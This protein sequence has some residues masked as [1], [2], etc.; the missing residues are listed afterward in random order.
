MFNDEG[1]VR[2]SALNSV[3]K[4][5]PIHEEENYEITDDEVVMIPTVFSKGAVASP[6]H[7][8]TINM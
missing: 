1:Q 3:K 7:L 4:T 8:K 5:E 6:N 2:R